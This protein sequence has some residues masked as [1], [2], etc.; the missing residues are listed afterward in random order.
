MSPVYLV[1]SFH[2]SL[3][4][5]LFIIKSKPNLN[6]TLCFMYV[7]LLANREIALWVES[8][9]QTLLCQKG[10]KWRLL[11]YA[12]YFKCYWVT[13]TLILDLYAGE[14][15]GVI[16][17]N[18]YIIW[19]FDTTSLVELW[20]LSMV[21]SNEPL[22]HYFELMQVCVWQCIWSTLEN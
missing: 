11:S 7:Y 14:G 21:P 3:F 20:H 1:I 12:S 18:A 4:S 5:F 8:I 16:N 19:M 2:A 22:S 6:I 13:V 15:V 10:Q 9:K 17:L